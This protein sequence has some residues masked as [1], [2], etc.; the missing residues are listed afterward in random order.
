MKAAV[1]YEHHA[2]LI[3]T[4]IKHLTGVSSF[5]EYAVVPESSVVKIRPDV[6]LEVAA[7]VGCGVMTGVGAVINTAKVEPGS[8]VAVIGCGGVGL[9]TVQGTVLA[10]A[11]KIIAI[12]LNPHKLALAIQFGATHCVNP[13]EGDP[14]S[15]VLALT[16]GLGA[17]YSFEVIGRSDT[18]LQAYHSIR[19]GGHSRRGRRRQTG[20][21]AD[22]SHLLSLAGENLN[23][24]LLRLRSA[25]R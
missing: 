9:N 18:A 11:E 1:F 17:D 23:G 4:E 22:H 14:V 19:P 3:A 2:P 5:A 15:R 10:G 13:K 21:Y 16:D 7:L 24:L 25:K 6:P 8:S 20:R 12:D